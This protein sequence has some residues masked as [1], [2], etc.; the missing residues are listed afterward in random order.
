MQ[1]L[2]F[3]EQTLMRIK[4]AFYNHPLTLPFMRRNE[5]LIEIK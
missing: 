1:R 5:V 3:Q 2:F 4:Y